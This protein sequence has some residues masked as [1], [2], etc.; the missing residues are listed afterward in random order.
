MTNVLYLLGGALL[1]YLFGA[2]PFGWIFVKLTRG[3]DLRQVKSGRTGGTN[4]M[5]AAGPVV[6]GLTAIGDVL[7][8][9]AAIWIARALFGSVLPPDWLPWAEIAIGVMTIVGHNWS[10]FLGWGGGAGTGPNVGW[11]TA[12]WWPMFLVGGVV[13]LGVILATGMA[14]LASL[15]MAAMI[16]VVFAILYFLGIISSPA[17]IVGGILTALV[18]TWALRPNIRRIL[19]GNER[20]VGPAARRREKAAELEAGRTEG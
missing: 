16:P 18:V 2:I 1:G 12:V 10:I 4:A 13:V 9:A 19:A 20:V 17:Y 14:S 8:G 5:R 11:S 15:A 3:V 7:K 6:G